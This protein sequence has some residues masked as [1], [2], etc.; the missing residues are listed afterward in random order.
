LNTYLYA[1]KDDLKH[2]IAWREPYTAWEARRLGTLVQEC[3]KR[4]IRFCYAISPG[5]DIRFSVNSE[6][7]LLKRKLMQ[8]LKLGCE[9]FALLFDDI[10]DRL[11]PADRK[12][13]GT[14]AAAQALTANGIYFWLRRENSAATMFLCPTVYCGSMANPSVSECG[15]LR[16]LGEKVD[17]EIKIFWTGPDIISARISVGSIREVA[18]VLRRRPILWDNLYANDYDVRR[19]HLGPY[20]G[21]PHSLKKEVDGVLLNPNCQCYANFVPVRSLAS[22]LRTWNIRESKAGWGMA[23]WAWLGFFSIYA[24]RKLHFSDLRLLC[25]FYY[26]PTTVGPTARKFLD[27]VAK[28]LAPPVVGRDSL[29]RRVERTCRRV[30]R[31]FDALLGLEN[32][33]LLHAI[34]PHMWEMKERILLV[35]ELVRWLRSNPR[36]EGGF[37]PGSYPAASLRGCVCSELDRLLNGL[38]HSTSVRPG[39]AMG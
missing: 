6:H 33:T 19:L 22:W 21:R 13:F 34:Y 16:E 30:T 18:R 37:P 5:L 7:E 25:D 2:R 20:A 11:N 1:P 15:Y 14:Q 3:K 27:D 23:V 35:Q 32:R 31:L 38:L 29:L 4:G 9:S 8:V 36:P 24:G 17:R 39:M 26:L 12:R 28:L 10:P